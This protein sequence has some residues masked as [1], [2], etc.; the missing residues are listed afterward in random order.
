MELDQSVEIFRYLGVFNVRA[1][2]EFRQDM[3]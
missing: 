3:N 2:S 1:Y